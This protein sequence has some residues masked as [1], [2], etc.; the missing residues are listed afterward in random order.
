MALVNYAF[1]KG[2]KVINVA[3]FDDPSPELIEH[4]KNEHDLDL[5]IPAGEN[6]CVDGEYDGTLFWRV[7]KYASWVKDYES[8]TWVAPVPYPSD[9]IRVV[10]DGKVYVWDEESVSWIESVPE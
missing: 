7:P 8:N 10:E 6:A 2:N 5:L 1:I 3:V 4:F 9:G